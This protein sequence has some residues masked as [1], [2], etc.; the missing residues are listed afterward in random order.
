[1]EPIRKKLVSER[2]E[3][4]NSPPKHRET[5]TKSR[6]MVEPN[7]RGNILVTNETISNSDKTSKEEEAGAPDAS[8]PF[9]SGIRTRFVEEVTTAKSTARAST[10]KVSG[11]STSKSSTSYVE[12]SSPAGVSLL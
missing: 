8:I 1:M 3:R 4:S 12:K 7:I 11:A 2:N 5:Q 9:A 6:E 10:S